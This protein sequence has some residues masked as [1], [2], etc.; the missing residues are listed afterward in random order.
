MLSVG[1]DSRYHISHIHL[2]HPRSVSLCY[3]N[4]QNIKLDMHNL[5]YIISPLIND[6][7]PTHVINWNTILTYKHNHTFLL[8]HQ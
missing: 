6:V 7:K 1:A 3:I 8:L 5:K 4:K 2:N